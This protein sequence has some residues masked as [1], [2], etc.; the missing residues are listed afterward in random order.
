[1]EEDRKVHILDLKKGNDLS[2]DVG[3]GIC[4]NA[5]DDQPTITINILEPYER[6]ELF[7][8]RTAISGPE[9]KNDYVPFLSCNRPLD[10]GS[11][12][13]SNLD[14]PRPSDAA[15][16]RKCDGRAGNAK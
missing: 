8:A 5:Q 13:K 2:G 12:G 1:L 14:G 11:V 7:T 9:V 4:G 6:G 3:V 16:Q 15:C 10:L